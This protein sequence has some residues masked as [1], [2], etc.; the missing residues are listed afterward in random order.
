MRVNLATAASAAIAALLAAAGHAQ[1][2]AQ[3]V[4]SVAAGCA[5]LAVLSRRGQAARSEWFTVRVLLAGNLV[6]FGVS[7]AHQLG[8]ALAVPAILSGLALLIGAT[9]THVLEHRRRRRGR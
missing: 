4:I 2:P 5:F 9:W 3:V 1:H 8:V 7:Y 6:V